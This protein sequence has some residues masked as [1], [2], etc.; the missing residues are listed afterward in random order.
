VQRIINDQISDLGLQILPLDVSSVDWTRVITDAAYR[1]APFEKGGKEKGFRDAIISE[2]FV[3][4]VDSSPTTPR[5]CRIALVTADALLTAAVQARTRTA[6]NVRILPNLDELKGL[7]NTLVSQVG[8]DFVAQIHE[9]AA[10][11]FFEQGNDD[12]LVIR[13]N[14]VA[15]TK[16]QFETEL[17]ELPGGATSKDL[18]A[19]RVRTTRF[20]KKEGQRVFWITRLEWEYKAYRRQ[21]VSQSQVA[22]PMGTQQFL[23][24]AQAYTLRSYQQPI[25]NLGETWQQPT[26]NFPGNAP[27]LQLGNLGSSGWTQPNGVVNVFASPSE[28][29][30]VTT[31]TIS[32][33]VHWSVSVAAQRHT[34]SAAR[35]ELIKF[36]CSNWAQPNSG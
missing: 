13:E 18:E 15:R 31:G 14:I 28:K 21:G 24:S 10:K 20:N 6:T 2:A 19:V 27:P 17:V 11:Y 9:S 22:S 16:E 8:E 12:S 25:L 23:N 34:F 29:I 26:I 36:V 35:I 5:L 1:I 7:I 3:Q 32:F 4:L 30:L 33:D